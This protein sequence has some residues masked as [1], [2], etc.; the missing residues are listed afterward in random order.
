MPSRPAGV[1]ALLPE[2]WHA[3]LK[4]EAWLARS[5]LH[6]P[7]RT[8]RLRLTALYG[9]LFLLSGTG[10]LAITYGIVTGRPIN[11]SFGV[12]QSGVRQSV[13]NLK[14][15]PV[16]V[17]RLVEYSGCMH[18][19]GITRYPSVKLA[20][21][22]SA[23]A[24]SGRAPVKDTPQFRSATSACEKATHVPA[25]LVRLPPGNGPVTR[26]AVQGP[27]FAAFSE[28]LPTPQEK[29]HWLVVAGG[30]LGVMALVSVGLGW[31]MAGRALRPVRTMTA[32]ARHISEENLDARL[33]LSGPDD[34]LKDLADTF[35]GLLGRLEGAFESQRRFVANASHELRTPLA[36]MRTSVDVAVG[37]PNPPREVRALAAKLE[38]GLDQAEKL[39]DSLL[40]LARSQRGALGTPG[41]V[42]LPALA[43]ASLEVDRAEV[44]RLGLVVED[45]TSPAEVM[46]NETLLARMVANV[47]DNAV[48]H[49]IAGGPVRITSGSDGH[50]ARLVVENGG[51]VLGPERVAQLGEPFYRPG[52]ERL[53]DGNGSGL[54]LSIAKAVAAAHG[55]VIVLHARPEGGLQVVIELPARAGK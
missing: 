29:S 12:E 1:N 33:A 50:W 18:A 17:K 54:G 20:N 40:V 16:N 8:V 52:S 22:G 15:V 44:Q 46:G 7:R 43:Q 30:A 21:G 19:H 47:V 9:V 32:A 53:A 25:G 34:E 31:L 23:V 45:A 42:S 14:A 27:P 41:P 28:V 13:I 55:G 2:A 26:L 48:R 37:K 4:K 35:D 11:A 10:L 6:W 36:M 38:E 24:E 51:S 49:N 5:W 3:G 39:L